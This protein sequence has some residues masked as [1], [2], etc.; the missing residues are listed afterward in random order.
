M[1]TILPYPFKGKFYEYEDGDAPIL[2]G[3]FDKVRTR[4]E[5]EISPKG[6]AEL[7]FFSWDHWKRNE[8]N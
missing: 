5:P 2:E 6:T 3:R 8:K 1:G 7:N 4:P